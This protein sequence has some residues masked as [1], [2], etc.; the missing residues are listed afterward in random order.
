MST[1]RILVVEDEKHLAEGLLFNLQ[2]K[3]YEVAH[4]PDGERALA[5]L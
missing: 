3:G 5:L 2:A 1:F 4:A